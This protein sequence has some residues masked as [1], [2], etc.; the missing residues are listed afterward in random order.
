MEKL[1]GKIFSKESCDESK[2]NLFR[3]IAL[4]KSEPAIKLD[5]NPLEWWFQRE[6]LYPL[7]TKL[8]KLYLELVYCLNVYLV[9]PV[10]SFL[11]K[12]IL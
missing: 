11:L 10:L 5:S 2:S 12:E 6:H 7:T 3:E 8:V 1:L 9:Q 4:Y